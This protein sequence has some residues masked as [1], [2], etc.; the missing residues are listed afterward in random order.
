M[1][2]LE[3][4]AKQIETALAYYD[5][6]RYKEAEA[7]L[8]RAL[9]FEPGNARAHAWLAFAL[10]AQSTTANPQP[11]RLHEALREAK[12][13]VASAP[14]SILGYN[15]LGW[16]S[17]ALRRPDDALRAAAEILRIDPKSETGWELTSEGWIQKRDYS[18]ALVA[19]DAGLRT[20][21]ESLG[22][23]T[24][25]AQALIL[26]DRMK[27]ARQPL[28]AVLS[29]D[30][31]RPS[32]HTLRGWLAIEQN[33]PVSALGFFR[34]ALSLD[35]LSETARRGL[36][37]ALQ[38]R[39]PLYRLMV[40]YSLWASRFNNTES[41]IILSALASVNLILG[42]MARIFLPLYLIYLPWRMAYDFFVEF[43]WISDVL[44]VFVLRYSPTGRVILKKDEIAASNL[45]ALSLLYFLVNLALGL[46]FW[47]WG[48]LGGMFLGLAMLLP[49]AVVY[50]M[51]EKTRTRR[52]II[53]VLVGLMGVF[54]LFAQGLLF[55]SPLWAIV[56]GFF[57]ALGRLSL[58][59]IANLLILWGT[60]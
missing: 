57:F 14:A 52:V 25:R 36:L 17:L 26:L 41:F 47:Q 11:E 30:P 18:R 48:Y 53:A 27:E 15:A 4:A 56:P 37:A 34:T 31:T 6:R 12:V 20:A 23:L 40:R 44:F 8:R 21:P 19:A 3:G 54:G 2:T 59:W 50:R 28:D 7:A 42:G 1:K 49:A 5:L 39:N 55:V 22:L 10:E 43:S 29:L 46:L 51:R 60:A 9:M 45:F 33:D 32:A 35:P 13:A 38:A 16:V 58:P 24:N